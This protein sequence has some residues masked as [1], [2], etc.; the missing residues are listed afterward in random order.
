MKPEQCILIFFEFFY[1]IFK[2]LLG[3]QQPKSGRNGTQNEFF[4][5]TISSYLE[6]VLLEMK[7]EWFFLNF[8]NFL[9]FLNFF[10]GMLQPVS[11]RNGTVDTQFCTHNLIKENDLNDHPCTPKIMI[12]LHTSICSC[13]T[14]INSFITYHKHDLEI[15]MVAM[16]FSV[17]KLDHRI[18]RYRI[19][20]FAWSTCIASR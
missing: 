9:L 2:I 4:F 1:Y 15:Q 20:K 18:E 14:C 17:S 3:M 13:I 7:P 11:S 10:L 19:I 5:F 12:A 6:S 16:T 8:L